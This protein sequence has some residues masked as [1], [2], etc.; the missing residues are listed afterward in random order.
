MS[1]EGSPR[2]KRGYPLVIGSRRVPSIHRCRS[3]IGVDNGRKPGLRCN[4]AYCH[5]SSREVSLQRHQCFSVRSAKSVGPGSVVNNNIKPSSSFRLGNGFVAVADQMRGALRLDRCLGLRH[6][7]FLPRKAISTPSRAKN[8]HRGISGIS[9]GD[10]RRL[11]SAGPLVGAERITVRARSPRAPIP[12]FGDV[13]EVRNRV[14]PRACNRGLQ[15][16]S[17]VCEE[18]AP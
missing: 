17:T 6:R 13:W 5:V 9:S 2:V 8:C 4:A 15:S 3:P 1:K 16:C 11:P 18:P 10:E 12:G 14:F 7:P